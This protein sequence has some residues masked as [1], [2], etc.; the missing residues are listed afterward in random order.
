MRAPESVAKNAG[1]F[2]WEAGEWIEYVKCGAHRLVKFP[3]VV[4]LDSSQML[5]GR[6]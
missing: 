3:S 1:S 4:S 5:T 6:R 2:L